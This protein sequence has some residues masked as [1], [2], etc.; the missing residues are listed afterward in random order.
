MPCAHVGLEQ[1]LV[2]VCLQ[3]AQL[4]DPFGRFPISHARIVEAR[5]HQHRRIGLSR[6]LIIGRVRADKLVRILVL[7]RVAPFRPFARRERQAFVE[8]GRQYIDKRHM[9][10]HCA[11][12]RGIR[13]DHRAHQFAARRAARNRDPARRGEP[14]RDQPLRHVDEVVERVGPLLQLPRLVP[15]SPEIINAQDMRDC[16]GKAAVDQ[17]QPRGRE[18]RPDGN[19]ISAVAIEIE[20]PAGLSALAPHHR[21]G[22]RRAIARRYLQPRRLIER[23]VVAA[24]DFLRLQQLQPTFGHMVVIDRGGA[25]HRFIADPELVHRPFRIVTQ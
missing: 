1:Q 25:G 3:L 22:H 5:R 9:R 10:R 7:D 24:R 19:A 16:I 14:F 23:C 8:H 4:C 20:R 15:A 13:I 21:D 17:A 18:T 2:A 6:N 11:P 12:Q